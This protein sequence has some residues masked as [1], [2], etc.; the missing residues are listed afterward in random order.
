MIPSRSGILA[1]AINTNI[2]TKSHP[3]SPHAHPDPPSSHNSPHSVLRFPI[4]R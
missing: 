4:Y 3:D 1:E 2:L